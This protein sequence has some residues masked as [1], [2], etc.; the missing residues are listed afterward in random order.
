MTYELANCQATKVKKNMEGKCVSRVSTTEPLI[1]GKAGC[2]RQK[3]LWAISEKT[4]S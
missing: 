4:I 2:L 1:K 3:Q